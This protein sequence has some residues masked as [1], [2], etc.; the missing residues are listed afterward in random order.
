MLASCA[1]AVGIQETTAYKAE[2]TCVGAI[3]LSPDHANRNAYVCQLMSKYSHELNEDIRRCSPC[4]YKPDE[5]AE[6]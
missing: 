5:R 4:K 6:F 2:W 3:H 1:L